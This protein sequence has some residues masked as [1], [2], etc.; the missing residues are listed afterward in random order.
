M[1]ELSKDNVTCPFCGESDFDL[2]GLKSH[3]MKGY[4]DQYNETIT[5]EQE[6]AIWHQLHKGAGE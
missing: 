1:S 5:V 3:F 4:C 6:R 2:V